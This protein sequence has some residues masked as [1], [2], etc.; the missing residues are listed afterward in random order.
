MGWG[1]L[2]LR[3]GRLDDWMGC[4]DGG[5]RVHV[6]DCWDG[7]LLRVDFQ[8]CHDTGQGSEGVWK[9]GLLLFDMF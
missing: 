1:A 9:P 4:E 2:A 8:D 6:E 7:T 3:T 5:G